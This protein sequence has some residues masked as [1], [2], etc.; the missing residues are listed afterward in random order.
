MHANSD[1]A[2]A[3]GLRGWWTSAPR[4]GMQLIISP[5]EYRHLRFWA[6]VRIAAGIALVILGV[7]TGFGGGN[8]ATTHA[9]TLAFL[10]AA[11]ANVTFACWELSI[12]RA[13]DDRT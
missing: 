8:E 3:T 13:A 5:W 11:A 4:S 6:R 7:I 1:H 10:T 9:W 2:A 12:A